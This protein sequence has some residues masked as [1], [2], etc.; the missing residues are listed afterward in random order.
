M[1]SAF[2][3]AQE[4]KAVQISNESYD[5]STQ[6]RFSEEGSDGLNYTFNQTQTYNS[7]GRP[8][9]ADSD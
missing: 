8:S 9:D 7:Q 6:I 5:M 3:M 2:Q 4:P 1:K